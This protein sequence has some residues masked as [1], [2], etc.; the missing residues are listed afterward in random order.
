MCRNEGDGISLISVQCTVSI[1]V[2]ADAEVNISFL[3]QIE[4]SVLYSVHCTNINKSRTSTV[5][6]APA[7]I[8]SVY[9]LKYRLALA[10]WGTAWALRTGYADHNVMHAL[11]CCM[12]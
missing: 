1:T 8:G 12:S 6:S 9:M 10:Q 5:A 3:G 7:V 2:V 4:C 11:V